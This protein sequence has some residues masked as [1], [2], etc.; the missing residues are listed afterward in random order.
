M[1]RLSL[2]LALA[3]S[4]LLA[5]AQAVPRTISGQIVD[6]AG[7]PLIGA[8]ILVKGTTVGTVTDIDGNFG[9]TV[10]D[11]DG[12]VLQISY[13]GY[14]TQEVGLTDV[15]TYEITL[16]EGATLDEVVVTGLGIKKEKKALGYAV[17][18]LDNDE[19]ELRPEG[20]VSRILRGKVAGVDINQTS[21]LSGSG[22]NVIIRGYSS[23]TGSNQ[24]LFVVDG[25]PFNAS[26]NA[27]RNFDE[28]GATASSRFLDLD[29]NNIAE[30]SVLKGLSATVL[31]GENGRNG[32]VLITTKNGNVDELQK[33]LEVTIDQSVHSNTVYRIPQDQDLYG[34]GFW[35][36][37]PGAFSNWGAPFDPG[38][39]RAHYDRLLAAETSSIDYSGDV[40]TIPHPYSRDAL[41]N[42]F[43]GGGVDADGNPR[44]GPTYQ[45]PDGSPVPYEY[46]PYDNLE[47]FFENGLISNTS[48]SV[49]SRLNRNTALNVSYGY[50]SA[51]GFIPLD[52]YSRQNFGAGVATELLNGFKV[53]A[54]LNYSDIERT[55][56]PAG[57]S[58]SSNPTGQSLLSNVLYTPRSIDLFGLESAL[59]SDGSSIYYRGGNDIQ[60]PLWTVNNTEGV[61]DVSRFYGNLQVS[62]DLTDWLTASYRLGID[63]YAQIN[64]LRVNRGGRQQPDGLLEEVTRENLITDQ[65]ASLNFDV[66]LD[67][68]FNLSGVAGFNVR[69]DRLDRTD[70][71]SAGQFVFDL[72]QHDN[73]ITFN[74]LSET[75]DENLLGAL[76]SGT[77]GFRNYLYVNLQGRNDWTSTLEASER[78]V[79]YPS[80]SV[81]FVPTDAI[82]GLQNSDVLTFAKVRLGYGS[83][84]GYPDPYR[85]RSLLAIRTREYVGGSTILNTNSVSDQLGN[86]DLGPER[87]DE[88]ELGLDVRMFQNRVGIDLS[89]Y[90]KQSTDLIFPVDL[91][92]ATGFRETT[93]N[94]AEVTN[95][96]VEV[97]VNVTPVR[98]TEWTWSVNANFTRN[99]NVV[100]ALADGTNQFPIAGFTNLGNFAFPGEE[101]GLLYGQRVL[102]DDEGRAIIGADG[103][104]QVDP[105]LGIIGNPNPNY[106]L[107]GGTSLSWR[108]LTF[109]I[110]M[111]YR[112]G[113]DIF[114]VT[115]STLIS[116]G[117]LEDETDF[118]RFVPL[119]IPG[120]RN[121]GTDE[122]PEFV[123]NDIQITSTDA[124]W[125]NS[126]VFNDEQR[127]YDGS[128]FKI[129]EI[130]LSYAVSPELLERTPFGGIVL[131]ASAQNPYVKAFGFPDATGFDPEVTSLGVGNGQGFELMNVPSS[132]QIGGSV[133]LTF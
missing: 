32:V 76:F 17:T 70:T 132:K 129:R 99:E 92:P 33:K 127:I 69:S 24:P 119:V 63:N 60:H 41:A 65:L 108:G 133:R 50:R 3:L 34:N 21:G 40:P 53:Q 11:A 107:N 5:F 101:F 4:G 73:F 91:D 13:T 25:V 22:T 30:V 44:S 117:I 37:L 62:Y 98:T 52:R 48:V 115:P 26:T 114:A 105:E 109:D 100:D 88:F 14:E 28:G 121:V 102:R 126:G 6:D 96:G 112:D 43:V 110:L 42:E 111:S 9:L 15:D 55:A 97:G 85:T 46:R 68:D 59:P 27:D 8:S 72:F 67:E 120:V 16:A 51:D 124:Y 19:I 64:Q 128:Y 118:D 2:T 38:V 45:N 71:R 61:E 36:G 90:N 39:H 1:K 95:R 84:A 130:A 86:P 78:S 89:L 104:T 57:A 103:L 18:T 81:S 83:S 66:D 79:F 23:L 123:E 74:N 29:P 113:G 35:N 75:F 93:I 77:L 116:R 47:N 80:A 131:T 20:D 106:R 87:H 49:G 94:V 31:Y 56:P 58:F 54:S 82:P 12:A 7:E 122:A 125:R 10:E